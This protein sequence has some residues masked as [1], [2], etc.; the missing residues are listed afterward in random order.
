[1]CGAL[2]LVMPLSLRLEEME[3]ID[4]LLDE[5]DKFYKKDESMS[6]VMQPK[7]SSEQTKRF[8]DDVSR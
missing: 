2:I 5:A 6:H 8:D 3:D 4:K 7:S 1:M